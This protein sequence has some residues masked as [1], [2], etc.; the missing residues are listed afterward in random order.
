MNKYQ[1]EMTRHIMA[2]GRIKLIGRGASPFMT[3]KDVLK[4]MA[5]YRKFRRNVRK[6]QK[7]AL[8]IMNIGNSFEEIREYNRGFENFV[9][10]KNNLIRST[11]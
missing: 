2:Y 7:R 8:S 5:N 9:S 3:R 10:E 4:H 6:N 11:K 1:K